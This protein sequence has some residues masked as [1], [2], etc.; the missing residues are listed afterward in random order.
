VLLY[1]GVR[2][3]AIPLT[4]RHHALPQHAGQ[5]SLPGGAIDPGES[6]EAAAIREAEEEIGIT[7]DHVRLIGP[8]STLWVAVSNFVVHPMVG[9]ADV[10]PEF[11]LHPHEVEELIEVPLSELR[12]P[13]R[14]GRTSRQ[15]GEMEVDW[16]YFDLAGRQVWGATAMI[17]GEFVCLFEPIA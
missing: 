1:P 14:L 3:P 5:V 4:V 6:T 12:D 16:P 8:L 15:R 10:A 11:R 7:P 17:L 2:G 13:S 9:I